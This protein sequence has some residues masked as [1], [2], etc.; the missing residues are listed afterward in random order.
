MKFLIGA[1]TGLAFLSLATSVTAGSATGTG[2]DKSATI[3]SLKS[4]APQGAK[5]TDTSRET[6]GVPSGVVT[7]IFAQSHG[8]YRNGVLASLL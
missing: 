1:M 3:D 7:N 6:I 2:F 8:N 4:N 5:I